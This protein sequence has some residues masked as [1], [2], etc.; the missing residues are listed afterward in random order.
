MNT[1]EYLDM[2]KFYL[3]IGKSKGIVRQDVNLEDLLNESTQERPKIRI[4]KYVWKELKLKYR[5]NGITMDESTDKYL[6]PEPNCGKLFKTRRF[7]E[8]HLDKVHFKFKDFPC[9]GCEE[10]FLRATR[11]IN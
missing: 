11:K 4:K 6:C 8:E 7:V 9:P 3:D 10:N 2:L 1:K 5:Y